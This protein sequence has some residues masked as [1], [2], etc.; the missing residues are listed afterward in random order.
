[1]APLCLGAMHGTWNLGEGRKVNL[2]IFLLK[3]RN[4]SGGSDSQE[5]TCNA[6]YP[7]SIPGLKRSPGEENGY[8]LQ[9]SCLKN[10]MGRG[11]SQA[12]VLGVAELDRAE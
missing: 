10:S 1:M 2:F 4:F 6:G 5:S 9:H 12:I 7:S 3:Y 11:A 8:P